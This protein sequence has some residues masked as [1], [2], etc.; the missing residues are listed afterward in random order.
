MSNLQQRKKVRR[1]RRTR[2]RI[3]GTQSRPRLSVFRSNRY[4]YAQLIDDERRI[5]LC[6][7]STRPS[8]KEKVSKETK[9]EKARDVGTR[10]AKKAKECEIKQVLFDRGAY[11]YH[12]RV[13]EVAEGAR[14]EGL[15]F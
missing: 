12:G 9:K 11:R 2:A 15:M 5:T 1:A 6:S 7:V 4:T 10:I 14:A 13:Q 3:Q 8:G